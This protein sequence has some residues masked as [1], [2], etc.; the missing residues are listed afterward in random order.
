MT[1]R[2]VNALKYGMEVNI[3]ILSLYNCVIAS[4]VWEINK[5]PVV[6]K[7]DVQAYNTGGSLVHTQLHSNTTAHLRYENATR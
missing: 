2:S 3:H 1:M 5:L 6:K 7:R 4:I